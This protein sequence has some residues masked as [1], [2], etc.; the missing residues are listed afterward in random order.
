MLR[1]YKYLDASILRG[2]IIKSIREIDG[3]RID[4]ETED[5]KKY[6]MFHS[7][8]CCESVR[9]HDIKGNLQDLIGSEIISA[10]ENSSSTDWPEDVEIPT[11]RDSWTWTIYTFQ[12]EKGTVKI[13]WLGGG[14]KWILR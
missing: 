10:S 5:N 11:Y 13:R 3:E 14:I 7:Q 9:I 6:S 2:K 8:D 1:N 12:N 4:I